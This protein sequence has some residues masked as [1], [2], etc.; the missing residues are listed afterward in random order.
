MEERVRNVL[1]KIDALLGGIYY[2]K[3]LEEWYNSIYSYSKVES[4]IEEKDI[5]TLRNY[6]EFV[7]KSKNTEDKISYR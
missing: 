6:N 5:T 3:F 1:I 7:Q 4:V 2:S